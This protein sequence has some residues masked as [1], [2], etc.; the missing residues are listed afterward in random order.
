MEPTT[1]TPVSNDASNGLVTSRDSSTLHPGELSEAISCEYRIGSP[2][3]Y[4]LPGRRSNSQTLGGAVLALTKLQYDGGTDV[5]IADANG[6]IFE[7]PVSLTPSFTSAIVTGL[8]TTEI[9]QYTGIKNQ[10]LRCNGVD[11]NLIREIGAVPNGTTGNWRINGMQTAS[12]LTF[13]NVSVDANS[14]LVLRPTVSNNGPAIRAYNQTSYGS[15][16]SPTSAYD[17]FGGV[18]VGVISATSGS[19]VV[20]GTNTIFTTQL[21]QGTIIVFPDGVSKAVDIISNDNYLTVTTNLSA[22]YTNVSYIYSGSNASASSE[23]TYSEGYTGE[24]YILHQDDIKRCCLCSWMFTT[25]LPATGRILSVKHDGGPYPTDWGPNFTPGSLTFGLQYT[26]DPTIAT[27]DENVAGWLP[28]GLDLRHQQISTTEDTLII[29]DGVDIANKLRVRAIVKSSYLGRYSGAWMNVWHHVYDI[30]VSTGSTVGYTAENPISYGITEAYTD[31][32]GIVHES[33][34]GPVVTVNPSQLQLARSVTFTLPIAP[35]NPLATQYKIWRSVDTPGG[36]Y[37]VMYNIATVPKTDLS[38]TDQFTILPND[39]AAIALK[40]QYKILEILYSTGESSLTSYFSPPP[41][42]YMT[43]V[44]Q[45]CVCYFPSDATLGR[46]IYYSLPTPVFTTSIEQVPTQYYLDFQTS[47]NDTHKS[48]AVTNGGRSMLIFFE[49]YTMLVNSLPQGSD[50]GGFNNTIKEYVTNTRGC[51]GKFGCTEFTLAAG[52]TFVAAVDSQG[53]WITNGVNILDEWSTDLDWNT[54]FSSV[55]LSKVILVCKP[56]KRRLELL[57]TDSNGINKEYHFYYG[58]MK[59]GIE[60]KTLP[61]IT[62][63]HTTKTRCRLYTII[64]TNLAGFSGDSTSTGNVYTEDV[65]AADD[66]HGYDVTGIVPWS[67][68][69]GDVYVGGIHKAQI[70]ESANI[71][72]EDSPTKDIQM[73]G[74]FTRDSGTTEIISK[75]IVGDHAAFPKQMYWHQYC[76]RHKIGFSDLTNTASPAFISYVLKTRSAGGARDK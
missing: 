48:G 13:V 5:L 3:L 36:G 53:L 57:Y 34:M 35:I 63:P 33:N 71:K 64:G 6:K 72:F 10:W 41:K 1:K 15:Y 74:T 39:T 17:G 68:T 43:L 19:P 27:W 18:G 47:L 8:S 32:D 58:R 21:T 12:A 46:R 51:S 40:D 60:G 49:N 20:T 45:G 42:A 16:R 29:P 75:T 9:P 23:T 25:N 22:N 56:H 28:L 76:D 7:T 24:G 38:W 2:H 59:Q 52:Q 61:L 44:Y 70:A 31:S 11:N 4:K 67:W 55:D 69:L 37:P 65:Q 50:P 14:G 54:I 62:G 66:S 73:I 30:K 26:Y